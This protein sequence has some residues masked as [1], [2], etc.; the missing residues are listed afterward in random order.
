MPPTASRKPLATGEVHSHT[1]IPPPGLNLLQLSSHGSHLRLAQHHRQPPPLPQRL[2]LSRR[3]HPALHRQMGEKGIHL[4]TAHLARIRRYSPCGAHRGEP[5]VPPGSANQPGRAWGTRHHQASE[6]FHRIP[7]RGHGKGLIGLW[8][9][10]PCQ[11][12]ADGCPFLRARSRRRP[13]RPPTPRRG[14]LSGGGRAADRSAQPSGVCPRAYPRRHQPAVVRQRRTGRDRHP[15]QA[16]GPPGRRAARAGPGG[17][18]N[19]EPRHGAAGRPRRAPHRI[20][21]RSSAPQRSLP[22]PPLLAR[23]HALRLGG[24]AR[25]P[26]RSAGAAAGGGLQGLSPLG[27]G[28]LRAALAPAPAGGPHRLRQDRPT[29][30]PAAARRGGAGSGGPCP[31]PRQQLRRPRPAA[32]AQQRAL[33]KPPRRRPGLPAGGR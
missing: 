2:V 22:A 23:R 32:P 24:L 15:L 27:A 29:A 31:S 30:G 5:A 21:R 8:T 19:G 3:T 17:A 25:G 33:R 18:A 10:P 28:A 20:Q 1:A 16:T 13:G 14:D 9:L 7:L 11:P 26:A 4:H 6:H 12:A